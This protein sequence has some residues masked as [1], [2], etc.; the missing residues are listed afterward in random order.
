MP[1]RS[2]EFRR[3]LAAAVRDPNL[4]VALRRSLSTF[5]DRRAGAFAP[6]DFPAMQADLRRRKEDAIARLPELI[7]QF[8]REAEAV[9]AVVH[10][11]KTPE[12]ACRIIADNATE[13]GGTLAANSKAMSTDAI[14]L[15]PA[16]E[17]TGVWL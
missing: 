17:A 2:K 7:E 1:A 14:S 11:A 10:L 8:T 12:D 16:L 5:R 13:R 15:T 4:A 9:G 3:R 6:L